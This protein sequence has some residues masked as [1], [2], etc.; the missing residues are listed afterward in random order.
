MG[1][2]HGE[3][4]SQASLASSR[5]CNAED[6]KIIRNN[7][8]R[9]VY[10]HAFREGAA[11]QSRTPGPATARVKSF[12]AFMLAGA[13]LD[14]DV[15]SIDDLDGSIVCVSFMGNGA[16]DALRVDDIRAM[17]KEGSSSVVSDGDPGV[18]F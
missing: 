9:P 1:S 11:W 2:I 14:R 8:W 18:G 12:F 7:H 10:L 4:E 15:D 5:A 17:L 16:S 13:C 6:A 3:M